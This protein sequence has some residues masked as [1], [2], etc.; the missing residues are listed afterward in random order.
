MSLR[1]YIQGI[2]AVSPQAT[3]DHATFLD[4]P[5]HYEE[6][7]LK[8]VTP[9]FKQY[10]NPVT[11]RRMSRIIRIGMSAAKICMTDAGLAMPDG[12]LTGT[13]YGCA[14]DTIK[15]LQEM[16]ANNEQHLTPTH[17]TQST[18]NALSGAIALS[19]RCTNYNT[20]YVHRAFS[21]ESGVL[22]AMMQI[23]D[24]P[25]KRMLIG[26]F[27]ETDPHHYNI[28]RRV[29]YYKEETVRNFDLYTSGTRGTIQGEGASF[30]TLGAERTGNAYATLDGVQTLF[31]IRD[32]AQLSRAVERF[33][34]AQGV[35]AADIDVVV[36][37]RSGCVVNDKLL[38]EVQDNLLPHATKAYYKHLTGEYS[39]SAAFGA[40]VAARI[41]RE[42]RIP[43]AMLPTGAPAAIRRVLYLNQ[44]MGGEYALMLF[45]RI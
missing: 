12:I 44:Y 45:S 17:F 5:L 43:A 33:L 35:S 24:A 38:L 21:F 2:G 42:Q 29:G 15:F 13:G 32:A 20:T 26:G 36:S 7:I 27:D 1:Y 8:S 41:L 22:D 40:W 37:G 11:L 14:D 10:I 18:Y 4:E 31:G 28:T 39:A 6:N 34:A 16:L 23:A 30:I 25:Q 3:W 19:L 9:D